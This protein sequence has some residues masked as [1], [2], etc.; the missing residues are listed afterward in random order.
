MKAGSKV[1]CQAQVDSS[2][3]VVAHGLRGGEGRGEEGREGGR[4]GRGGEGRGGEGRGGIIFYC[5][6]KP[7]TSKFC[8]AY[9]LLVSLLFKDFSPSTI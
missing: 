4:E 2:Q 6:F 8:G 9:N 3:G 1:V 5:Q 7:H